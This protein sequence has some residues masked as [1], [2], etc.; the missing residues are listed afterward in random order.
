MPKGL[1]FMAFDRSAARAVK[2]HRRHGMIMCR[3]APPCHD[4]MP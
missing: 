1:L 3:A 2:F 4:P